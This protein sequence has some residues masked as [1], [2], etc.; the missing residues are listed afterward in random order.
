MKQYVFND[1]EALTLIQ[2]IAL[3]KMSELQNDSRKEYQ[4]LVNS[5]HRKFHYEI[6]KWLQEIGVE[7]TY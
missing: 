7:K 1:I 4:D 3:N 5:I 2:R 6:V